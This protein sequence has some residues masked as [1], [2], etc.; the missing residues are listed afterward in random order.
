MLTCHPV[1][2]EDV[3]AFLRFARKHQIPYEVTDRE[4]FRD[5]IRELI[6]DG[7]LEPDCI[8]QSIFQAVNELLDREEDE[9]Y[10]SAWE[11][12]WEE[13]IARGHEKGFVYE[14][15]D[16]LEALEQKLEGLLTE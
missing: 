4:G 5:A 9:A 7:E 13:F 6:E 3:L 1:S 11:P 10:L 12:T 8:D 14:D 2:N 16:E 15:D